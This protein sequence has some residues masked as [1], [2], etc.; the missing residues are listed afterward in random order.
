[1][2]EYRLHTV[3]QD[4]LLLC[5]DIYNTNETV[6]NID[7]MFICRFLTGLN[8]RELSMLWSTSISNDFVSDLDMVHFLCYWILPIIEE[9]EW[10]ETCADLL[11]VIDS[12]ELFL[13]DFP[14]DLLK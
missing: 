14:P 7:Y 1:M 6:R 10:Y 13:S 5:Y 11:K 2:T 9:L 8:H 4:N 12:S 3:I